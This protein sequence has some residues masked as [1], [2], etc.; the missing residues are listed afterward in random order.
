MSAL[1]LVAV[2]VAG[3]PVADKQKCVNANGQTACGFACKS[4]NGKA[5]CAQTPQGICT[6]YDGQIVCFD[7]PRILSTVLGDVPAPECK[8]AQ[9]KTACGYHCT[10]SMSPLVCAM[11][12]VGVC[13]A[14]YGST[15]CFDPPE[16]VFAVWGKSVPAPKCLAQ[17][18]HIACGYGC[19]AASGNLACAKTPV[20]VCLAK[21]ST[22]K[23]FDPPS[24]AICA[25]GADIKRPS[26]VADLGQIVCGYDCKSSSG[27]VACA[28]T[29]RG[30]CADGAGG[31][32]CFDPPIDPGESTACYRTGAPK[33]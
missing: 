14:R 17:D 21:D 27:K 19:V 2:L 1:L 18:G 16:E 31:V 13:E 4:E 30:S 26:C 32:T 9:G 24:A 6:S 8:V 7:P 5:K 11:T 22:A 29:P 12:P 10:S 28:Q 15:V 3:A 25:F 20:G 33:N 23:C